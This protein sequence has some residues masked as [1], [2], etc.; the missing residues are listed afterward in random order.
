MKKGGDGRLLV[1]SAIATGLAT[2]IKGVIGMFPCRNHRRLSFV[3]WRI[4]GD[5]ANQELPICNYGLAGGSGALALARIIPWRW[6]FF[7]DDQ[8]YG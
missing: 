7:D 2:M 3:F 1:A 4:M 6:L 8:R 5:I